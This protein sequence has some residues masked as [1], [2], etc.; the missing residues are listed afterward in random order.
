MRYD[1]RH[2]ASHQTERLPMKKLLIVLMAVCV[3][4]APLMLFA[5]DKK[6]PSNSPIYVITNDDGLTHTYASFYLAGG[7]QGAPTLTYQQSVNTTGLGIGGG[8]FGTPRLAMV[9]S[10]SPQCLF[11]SDAGSGDIA[12]L[13]M[14]AQT[15]VG[16]FQ[17]S[18]ND[19][20]TSNGIGMAV[21]QNYLYAGYTLS[22][23]IATFS[24]GSGCQLS[25]LGDIT[26]TPL[27]GGWIAGMALNGNM[28]VV[29]YIDGS[30]QSFNT[31][32]GIP[33]S[34]N[35][36]QNATGFASAFFPD[37]VDIT[38][39][40]HYAIFGDA[41]ITTTVE[42]SDLSSGKLAPTVMY[43]LGAATNAIGPGVNSA[44]VRLSPDESLLYIGNSQNAYVS[45]AFFNKNTGKVSAGCVSPPLTNFYN[46]WSYVGSLQTRDTT[47]TGN[48]LYVAEFGS[49]IGIVSVTSTGMTCTLTEAAGSPVTDSFSP[50]LLSIQA[51]PPRLF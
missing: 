37:S 33:T 41:A 24:V 11:V 44:S 9:P 31:A 1:S 14:P 43:L 35:D 17:G 21:N 39:D 49:S 3:L 19:N 30:I 36:E 10:S 29:T 5:V 38:Q 25:F 26:V 2:V 6:K 16:T 51:Y 48:V 27:N 45:A 15:L 4:I 18:T 7:T 50:G 42:V 34:N 46:P 20:G 40:G 13:N 22:N 32:N 8:F 47:G 23:T 28:L 12:A